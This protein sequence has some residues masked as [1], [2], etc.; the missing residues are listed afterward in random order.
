MVIKKK[1]LTEKDLQDMEEYMDR[2]LQENQVLGERCKDFLENVREHLLLQI[3]VS[4]L[5]RELLI[6]ILQR[7]LLGIS[8]KL[9]PDK[10]LERSI[11]DKSE[12]SI[13]SSEDNSLLRTTVLGSLTLMGINLEKSI[14]GNWV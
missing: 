9:L 8:Q 6:Y 2:L 10:K 4:D 1:K 13:P 11:L 3:N 14:S 12:K 5:P 7:E